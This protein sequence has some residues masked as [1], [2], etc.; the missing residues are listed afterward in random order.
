MTNMEGEK[1]KYWHRQ[2]FRLDPVTY[3][4]CICGCDDVIK[5]QTYLYG[6]SLASSHESF[7]RGSVSN[8]SNT[9]TFPNCSLDLYHFTKTIQR[10]SSPAIHLITLLLNYSH[11]LLS[12]PSILL[13]LCEILQPISFLLCFVPVSE[14]QLCLY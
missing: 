6:V 11:I 7:P 13:P 8:S 14:S 4:T 5:T 12:W 3:H 10:S 1:I 2:N 9:I